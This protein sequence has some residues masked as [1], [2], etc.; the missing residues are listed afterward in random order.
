MKDPGTENISFRQR[1]IG[2]WSGN[3]TR[4]VPAELRAHIHSL[5]AMQHFE[6]M[7]T[8]YEG[9]RVESSDIT[10]RSVRFAFMRSV[11]Y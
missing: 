2:D 11:G 9:R 7:T 5:G 4:G 3:I 10:Y 6:Q 1:R 8:L